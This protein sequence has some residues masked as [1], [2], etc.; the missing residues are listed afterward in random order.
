MKI[1]LLIFLT[2]L[3]IKVSFATTEEMENFQQKIF[4]C[5]LNN[6]ENNLISDKKKMY[7]R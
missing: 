7:K 3:S 2:Y 5:K 6:K 4:F 1:N